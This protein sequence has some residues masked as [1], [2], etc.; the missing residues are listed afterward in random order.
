MTTNH[1]EKLDPAL[2]RP[3][4]INR[5]I[6]L[7]NVKLQQAQSMIRHYFNDGQELDADLENQLENVFVDDIISPAFLES[8]CA[9]HNDVKDLI[10][11]LEAKMGK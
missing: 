1:P 3:G 7:G 11:E 9:E 8:M 4:R 5:K 10:R 2:I 6:Y